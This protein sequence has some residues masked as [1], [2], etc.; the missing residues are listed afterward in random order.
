MRTA[1]HTYIQPEHKIFDTQNWNE[2]KLSTPGPFKFL[3]DF[4]LPTP[5][6]SK[7]NHAISLASAPIQQVTRSIISISAIEMPS[8]KAR[9]PSGP[10]SK[11]RLLPSFVTPYK[12]EY[13]NNPQRVF[14]QWERF[15]SF[16]PKPSVRRFC[17]LPNRSAREQSHRSGDEKSAFI[18]SISNNH[19]S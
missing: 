12:A 19:R 15:L 5:P 16:A 4:P 11:W 18:C 13:E 10:V 7:S 6:G 17:S 9:E 2:I 8:Q 1:I 3:A 14:D